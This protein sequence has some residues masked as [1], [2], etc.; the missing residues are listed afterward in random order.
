MTLP[1]TLTI[2]AAAALI[3]IWLATRVSRLRFRDKVSVGDGGNE[4]LTS[5][6]RAH[7]NF[8]EYTPF[9]LILLA[10]VELSAGSSTWLWVAAIVFILARLAHPFG[11]ERRAPNLMRAGGAV[12]TWLMLLGLALYALAIPYFDIPKQRPVYAA[13]TASR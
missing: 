7:A 4:R 3:N 9:F 8:V 12:V 1:I 5:R 2:A 6:M 10:L 11:M 13:S